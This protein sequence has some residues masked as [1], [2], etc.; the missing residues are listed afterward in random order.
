[1]KTVTKDMTLREIFDVEPF[2]ETTLARRGLDAAAGVVS[3]DD[4]LE[5][6]MLDD[7]YVQEDIDNMVAGLNMI[8]ETM[9]ED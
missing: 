1:M 9:G 7:H 2:L 4:T 6:V 8:L 5:K 3:Y